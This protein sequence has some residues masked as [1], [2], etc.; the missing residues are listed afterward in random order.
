[1]GKLDWGPVF[2]GGRRNSLRED[3]KVLRLGQVKK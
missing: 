2:D 3:S 1:M